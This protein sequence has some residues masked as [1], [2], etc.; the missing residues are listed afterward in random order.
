MNRSRRPLAEL[1]TLTIALGVLIVGSSVEGSDLE[2]L[3][4]GTE[5]LPASELLWDP[6][7]A[8]SSTPTTDAG[9]WTTVR[10]AR[11]TV[12]RLWREEAP[13]HGD[14]ISLWVGDGS[15][16][17]MRQELTPSEDGHSLL[18]APDP[19]GT[20]EVIARVGQQTTD[21]GQGR[22]ALEMEIFLGRWPEAPTRPRIR[23][24]ID[25]AIDRDAGHHRWVILDDGP[26][27]ATRRYLALAPDQP[28]RFELRGPRRLELTSRLRYPATA[29][30]GL[31]LYRL[32]AEVGEQPLTVLE[33]ETRP[34]TRRIVNVHETDGSTSPL[35]GQRQRGIL[36]VPAGDHRVEIVASAAV[37]LRLS[38]LSEPFLLSRN[39]PEADLPSPSPLP[40]LWSLSEPFEAPATPAE[41]ELLARRL[42]RDNSHR[43]GALAGLELL[44]SLVPEGPL[45]PSPIGA[46]IA[47][48][49]RSYA[50]HYTFYRDLLPTG[51]ADEARPR[52]AYVRRQPVVDSGEDPE[53]WVVPEQLL[54]DRLRGIARGIF[55]TPPAGQHQAT[56]YPLPHRAA[57][58]RLRLLVAPANCSGCALAAEVLVQIDNQEPRRL[59]FFEITPTSAAP[60]PADATLRALEWQSGAPDAGTLSG[61]F[62]RWRTP[63]PRIAAGVFELPL[64]VSARQVRVWVES[65]ATPGDAADG[66][67]RLALQV[68]TS[69]SFQLDE[70]AWLAATPTDSTPAA[71]RERANQRL[72]L[73]RLLKAR[74]EPLKASVAQDWLPPVRPTLSADEERRLVDRATNLSSREV[75]PQWLAAL[76]IWNRLVHEGSAEARR[77]ALI[78]RVAALEALGEGFL[79]ERQLRA[80]LLQTADPR[81]RLPARTALLDRAA[82]QGDTDGIQAIHAL[83]YLEEPTPETASGLIEALLEGGDFDEALQVVLE[84]DT[85]AM[86]PELIL[87]PAWHLGWWQ[88]FEQQLERLDADK[89]RLW[90]GHRAVRQGRL[91]DALA[92]YRAGGPEGRPWA[93][94]ITSGRDIRHRLRAEDPDV[95]QCALSDW[96]IWQADHP[97]PRQWR[98]EPSLITRFDGTARLYAPARD[99]HAMVPKATPTRPVEFTV[100]GPA[101]LRLEA[102]PIHL[103]G[104]DDPAGPIDDWLLIERSGRVEK[105][106]INGNLPAAALV[107]AQESAAWLPGRRLVHDLELGPGRHVLT[108]RVQRHEVLIRGEIERPAMPLGL[109]PPLTPDTVAFFSES[110]PRRVT[111][112]DTVPDSAA[113]LWLL[114]ADSRDGSASAPRRLAWTSSTPSPEATRVAA[115]DRRDRCESSTI[116]LTDAS[117]ADTL[118]DGTREDDAAIRHQMASL[119]ARGEADPAAA[120]G[121]LAEAAELHR[122]HPDVPGL[123]RTFARLR[124]GAGWAQVG[125]FATGAGVRRLSVEGRRESPG[126]RLR[127]ALRRPLAEGEVEVLG[128]DRLGLSL[129]HRR[130]TAFELELELA[131][132]P[133]LPPRPLE[134]RYQLRGGQIE[135]IELH[136]GQT[137]A[138]RRLKVSPGDQLL[139]VWIANPLANQSLRVRLREEGGSRQPLA[140]ARQRDYLVA[141]RDQP[142]RL[143]LPGPAML[144]IDELRRESGAHPM[145]FSRYVYL[146][147]TWQTHEIAPAD[148]AD[149]ALIRVFRLEPGA[150]TSQVVPRRVEAHLE[151]VPPPR[152]LASTRSFEPAATTRTPIRLAL[153]DTASSPL[154]PG[155][156]SMTTGW[157]Q[158]RPLEEDDSSASADRFNSLEIG[159]RRFAERRGSY[160]QGFLESRLRPDGEATLALSGIAWH[161]FKKRPLS[162][163]LATRAYYQDVA[164]GAWSVRLDAAVSHFQRL[165][166]RV[167]HAPRLRFFVRELSLDKSEAAAITASGAEILDQ[168]VFTP[169]KADHRSGL[170]LSDT[171]TWRPWLDSELWGRLTL[172]TNENLVDPDHGIV[173]GGWRQ[174]LGGFQLG[175]DLRWI[176]FFRDDDR[177]STANRT[178]WNV[179]GLWQ[180]SSKR[181]GWWQLGGALRYDVDSGTTSGHVFITLHRDRGRGIRDFRPG[182][183]D[184]AALHRYQRGAASFETGAQP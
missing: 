55:L 1:L 113:A 165:S 125:T 20:A 38:S 128:G 124:R 103:Q 173:R 82:R 170:R 158:R 46:E 152:R 166:P 21:A 147:E 183:I 61:P 140:G 27:G 40:A 67:P 7:V 3:R 33:Y 136:S 13:W 12:L 146:A 97:G 168:D 114:P 129:S 115:V 77:T 53:T 58:S 148:G 118:P 151:P 157:R 108:V 180:P 150:T 22:D 88:I 43:E 24:P 100:E 153:S 126:A 73:E 110:T 161:R 28:L 11:D 76:E 69:G 116:R 122:Q 81:L 182:E 162:L 36:E 167:T 41:A 26:D 91:D 17:A 60:R 57:D 29:S 2:G 156:W 74:A 87:R 80:M 104:A 51:G 68:E 181:L 163:Q 119:V 164:G 106:A 159:H 85:D 23:R 15:G 30:R 99:R 101:R 71:D 10:V 138:V 4:S 102:R 6:V 96:Q 93:E 63:A 35:L 179:E 31:Q 47:D 175:V 56:T 135:E 137:R 25:V 117:P 176:T 75:E 132:I 45:P 65:S 123:D 184:F 42:G 32:D 79:A 14:E 127:S 44:R 19:L 78:G 121:A 34:E 160:L 144:R 48:A 131:D 64:P 5:P 89:R 133:F 149:E 52:V 177:R 18:W 171:L 145:T 9:A 107:P 120:A 86:A 111:E 37:Y 39:R 141:T 178:T 169:Y 143:P 98:F 174:R 155:T 112:L 54:G 16:V 109:L 95:R 134:A 139:E 83:A 59:R 154:S 90:Q 84:A 92:H 94:A 49:A 8:E 105:V 66:R 172:T 142:V 72:P 50:R 62:S 130:A 70:D